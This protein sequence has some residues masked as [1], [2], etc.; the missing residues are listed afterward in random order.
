M[1]LLGL[2]CGKVMGNSEILVKEALMG[3]EEFGGVDVEIVRLMDLNIKPC[4]GCSACVQSLIKKGVQ[5][6]C[7]I[8]GDDM[9]FLWERIMECDGLIVSA[10]VY[11]LTLPG[12]LKVFSDRLTSHDVS[13]LTEVSKRMGGTKANIDSRS[14]KTRVGA[15]I[16]VG[17]GDHRW[18]SLGVPLM[19]TLTLL[20]QVTI[21]DQLQVLN[22]PLPGQVLLDEEAIKRARRLGCNVAEAMNKPISEVKF[23]GDDPGMCPVCHSN[24]LLVKKT[25]PVECPICGI[26]GTLRVEG[27]EVTVIFEEGELKKSL[28]SLEGRAPHFTQEIPKNMEAYERRKD[29][30]RKK[31]EKYKSYKSY[32]LPHPKVD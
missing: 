14:F 8:K 24:L 1:K 11:I 29:E 12:Y 22:A 27:N 18:V 20:I 28:L 7:V 25:L 16:V 23:M 4:T 13:F 15:F 17:G 10:P 2:T 3:A 5:T 19:H 6:G 31:V 30:I 26:R 32:S 9:P 21:V